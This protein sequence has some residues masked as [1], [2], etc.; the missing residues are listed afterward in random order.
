MTDKHFSFSAALLYAALTTTA[1]AQEAPATAPALAASEP[2]QAPYLPYIDQSKITAAQI[3]EATELG[4]KAV[5][6]ILEAYETRKTPEMEEF[7]RNTKRKADSIANEAMAEDRDKILEFLGLDPQADTGLYYFVSWSM[8]LELIRS[9]A[10]EAMWSGG[11]LVFKGIPKGRDLGE[12]MMKDMQ[13]LVYGKGAAANVS[14]DPRLFDAYGITSVPTI[15]FT[16]VKADMQCQGVNP[17]T[18]K[19]PSG[20][21]LSYDTCPAL[22]PAAYWKMTGAITSNY[23]IQ[24]FIEDG[25]TMAGPY[26]KAL[27]RGWSGQAAPEKNQKAFAGKWEDALS[28]SE[29]LAVH[30]AAR[31]MLNQ[32]SFPAPA[33]PATTSSAP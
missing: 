32:S 17:V 12:V 25:A 7:A 8:P 5:A 33:A 2:E 24:T 31:A 19:L 16:T 20:E 1:L 9:Y 4:Q 22:D 26:M 18:F 6:D 21:P 3:K 11:T 29:Q 14:L 23:A 15:V 13:Q 27:A 10:I 28:P 30:E